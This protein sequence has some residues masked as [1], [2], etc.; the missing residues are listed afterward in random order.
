M[1]YCRIVNDG[2]S[3]LRDA[4]QRTH[5]ARWQAIRSTALE[6]FE[7]DNFA[8]VSIEQIAKAAGVSRR[9][10]FNY[11]PTKTAVLFDPDPGESE[12]LTELLNLHSASETAWL[13]LTRAIAAYLGSQS[14]ILL[15]R[16][17]ILRSDSSLGV[18][19]LAANVHFEDSLVAWLGH[20]GTDGFRAQVICAV[21]LAVTRES[22][23]TWD[24]DSGV[25]EFFSL[26]EEGFRIAG[27]DMSRELSDRSTAH[28]E[29]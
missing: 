5:E 11:F 13:T 14:Q 20:H 16:R 2:A 12:R 24:P 17:R 21:V 8:E 3:E 7:R 25:E 9:T 22:F 10:F 18:H 26:L 4:Q 29:S 28:K 15:T 19:H 1:T 23:M 27:A 6:L